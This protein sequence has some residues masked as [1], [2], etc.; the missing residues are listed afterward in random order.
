[1]Y[2]WGCQLAIAACGVAAAAP[3]DPAVPAA[4]AAACSR[5]ARSALDGRPR[6]RFMGT[7]S[8]D[9]SGSG[10]VR[11]RGIGVGLGAGVVDNV[12]GVAASGGAA[13]GECSSASGDAVRS[14]NTCCAWRLVRPGCGISAARK[15]CDQGQTRG[16]ADV[17][18]VW[19]HVA[20]FEDV[21]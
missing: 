11:L 8:A 19:G 14:A 4:S 17:A 6:L 20:F 15:E 5:S 9:R 18:P 3:G 10:L 21:Y 12:A 7:P 13:A 16:Q 2:I 1:M